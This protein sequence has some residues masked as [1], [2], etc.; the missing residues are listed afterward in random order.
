MLGTQIIGLVLHLLLWAVLI[1]LVISIVF[2]TFFTV[3]TREAVIVERFGK[4]ARV[5]GPGLNV[6]IPLIEKKAGRISTQIQEIV[7]PVE[8]KTKD[9]VTVRIETRIQYSVSESKD[10]IRE[11]FYRLS[12]PIGQ[13]RSWSSDAILSTVPGM[14]LD[15]AFDQ[16]D[17]IALS[18]KANLTEALTAYGYTTERVLISNIEMPS[19]VVNAMNEVNAAQ[20]QREAAKSLAEADR[21]KRVIQAEAE[22]EAKRLQGQG[23]ANERKAIADGIAESYAALAHAGINPA[24]VT[25]VLLLTQYFD[26]QALFAAK[27]SSTIMLPGGAQGYKDLVD[28]IREATLS[29]NLAKDAQ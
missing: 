16:K 18:V 7:F 24:E 3:R 29:A 13:I 6:K 2:G 5:A 8:T 27:G 15:D 12:D 21:T 25:Q 28:G 11:A 19:S 1:F 22:A 26:T 20:R 9:N 23:I 14:T 17:A 10:V 4:F